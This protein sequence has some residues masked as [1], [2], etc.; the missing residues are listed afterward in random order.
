MMAGSKQQSPNANSSSDENKLALR[1]KNQSEARD[2]A[3]LLDVLDRQLNSEAQGAFEDSV[4]ASAGKL[5]SSMS[6][7]RLEQRS[8]SQ[9]NENSRNESRRKRSQSSFPGG[10]LSSFESDGELILP[11]MTR[12]PNHDWGKL[13]NQ[14]AEDAVEGRRDEYDPEFSRS[15]QAYFKAIGNQ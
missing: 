7:Q 8:A 4:K 2:M 6:Q 3:R 13:R 11:G 15:I 14:R 9:S 1:D 10:D 5:A 12:L